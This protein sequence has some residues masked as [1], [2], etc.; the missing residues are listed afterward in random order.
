MRI[1]TAWHY[2]QGVAE[3][4]RQQN[5]LARTQTQLS[6]NQKWRTAADDPAGWAAAQNYDQ[7]L[8]QNQQYTQAAQSAQAR[9]QLGEDSLASGIGLLQHVRELVVQANTASQSDS[10]RQAIAKELVSIRD[11]LLALA[12]TSDGQGRYL[13]GGA[14]D[15]ELPFS[16]NGS[17]ADYAGDQTTVSAQIGSTRYV[18]QNDPGDAVFMGLKTGNGRFAVSA[19]AGNTGGAALTKA[20]VSD[21]AAWDGGSYTLRFSDAGHYE[22][23]DGGGAVLQ[24]GSYA[25]GASIGFRG[26]TLGFSGTPAA[27]DQFTLG[28]STTQDVFALVD[29]LAT[30]VAQPQDS[31]AQRAQI[32][33]ALQQGLTALQGAEDHF[34]DVRSGIGIRLNAIDDALDVSAAVG[35]HATSAASD[36]RDLDYAD[37]IARLQLQMT[38]LE[39]AQQVYTKVQ[40]LSLFDYLR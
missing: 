40:G 28:P 9:L 23:V 27:G 35:E 10:S 13:F 21:A 18:A 5:A 24:S 6:A 22:I 31:E 16:W 29:G 37:A 34:G 17:S 39:A 19:A 25:D 36:L 7:L 1:S 8:A 4:Q 26:T 11:Q 30:L 14:D 32:Q 3:M 20:S 12:N 33:T 38:T 15:A 2:Q